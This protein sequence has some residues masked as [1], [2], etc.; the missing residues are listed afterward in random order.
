[1][2]GWIEPR[3]LNVGPSWRW[4]VS[5]TPRPLYPRGKN[6]GYPLNGRL[7]GSQVR[8]GRGDKEKKSQPLPGIETRS[9]SS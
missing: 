7:G 2:N 1:M 4:V 5:F 6:T 3:I 9:S 8:S